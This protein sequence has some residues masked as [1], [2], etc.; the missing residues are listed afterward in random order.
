MTPPPAAAARARAA[1]SP[2]PLRQP[3]APRRVSGPTRHPR[4]T[5]QST[6]SSGQLVARILDAP[7]LD[8]LIRGRTWI[9]FIAFALLGI[10][11]M[12]VTILRLGATIGRSATQIQVLTQSNEN[13]ETTIAG[14]EPGGNVASEAAS[15]GM[16]YPPAGD[17]AYLHYRSAD[18][19]L[20][21]SLAGAPTVPLTAAPAS[22]LTA[23]LAP[24]VTSTTSGMAATAPAGTQTA[25]SLA[26]APA[27]GTTSTT[28]TT[29]ADISTTPAPPAS[30]GAT[31]APSATTPGSS[32]S[33]AGGS[34][35]TGAAVG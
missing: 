3:F 10:V 32:A 25:T 35:A 27:S 5:P 33:V 15:L 28:A 24:A 7:F 18:P 6:P 9:A 8:R 11:A 22:S 13:A 34:S 19:S 2:A 20:A 1:T 4:A 12:Q 16:V 31:V 17:V 21:A 23:T 26:T 29:Q 14:L 30:G